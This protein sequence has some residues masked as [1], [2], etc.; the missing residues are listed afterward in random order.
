MAEPVKWWFEAD[1]IQACNC[2][3]GCPCEFQAPP[4]KGFCEGSGAWHIRS[5]R[6]G[7]VPLD[8]LGLAFAARWP[9][10]L[11]LGGGTGALFIDERASEAQ[12]AA[13]LQIASGQAGGMPFEI[14][15]TTFSKVLDPFFVPFTFHWDGRNSRVKIGPYME[16]ETEPVKNPVTGSPEGVKIVHETGF[17]F[18][19]AEVVAGKT[20]TAS[21]GEVQFDWPNQSGFVALVRYAN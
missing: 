15:V 4:T 20:C 14:I 9:G 17:V 18:K 6:C 2:D 21:A 16:I 7:E 19:E 3:F 13:L 5:G 12:R 11:H 8:G 1:Y 10:A